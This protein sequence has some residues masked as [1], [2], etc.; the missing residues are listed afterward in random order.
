M[1]GMTRSAPYCATPVTF[2]TPSG[3]IGRVPTHLN[4]RTLSFGMTSSMAASPRCRVGSGIQVKV[5]RSALECKLAGVLAL[6]APMC[7]SQA[8]VIGGG[9]HAEMAGYGGE[10]ASA[11]R[12]GGF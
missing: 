9:Q 6:P 5:A 4:G 2:G 7:L 10:R 8:I 1:P 3:R 11:A 12:D